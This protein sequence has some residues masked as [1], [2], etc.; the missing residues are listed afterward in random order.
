MILHQ[1]QKEIAKDK[2]RFRVLNCGRRFGKTMLAVE[3]IKGVALYKPE[4]RI[5]YIATTHDQARNIAWEEFKKEFNTCNK[6]INESRLEIIVPD[7]DGNDSKIFL[8]GW[9]NIET[10]RGRYFDFI[11]L[12]EVASMKNFWLNWQ[13]VLLPT[14]MDRA[15]SAMFIS[16]P[17]GFNHFYDL[18][19]LENE[20]KYKNDWKSFTYPTTANTVP[21][22]KDNIRKFI[23]EQKEQMTEDRFAQE[24]MADFRKM[25]GLVYP[26]FDRSKHIFDD[27]TPRPG[28]IETM[29]GIDWGWTNPACVLVIDKDSDSNYWVRAEWYKTQQ[30]TDQIIEIAKSYKPHKVYADPAEPDR[31]EE[32]KKAGLNARE[33]SKDIPNGLNAVREL[34]KQNRIMIH[35]DCKNLLWEL[36]TYHYPEKKPDR[37]EDERPVKEND[38]AVDS[39]RYCLYMDEPYVEQIQEDFN[40]YKEQYI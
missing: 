3:E 12:D 32:L 40:L 17:K 1:A 36:E 24:I 39:L 22:M 5:A 33:V 11:V 6:K 19:N 21:K 34:F 31:V 38:H 14:L 4:A 28:I 2:H 29:C 35:K 25:E 15:G 37:N 9:E 20:D 23:D 26:E 7:K 8:S 16:T 30:T 10:F 13:E 27:N 18:Y